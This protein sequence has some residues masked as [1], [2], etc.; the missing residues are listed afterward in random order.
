MAVFLRMERSV[1]GVHKQILNVMNEK[2]KAP[3]QEKIQWALKL[4]EI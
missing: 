2:H 3:Q 1:S 4:L